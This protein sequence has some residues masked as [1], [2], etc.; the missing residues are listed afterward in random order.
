MFIENGNFHNEDQLILSGWQQET[1]KQTE[2]ATLSIW[3]RQ[4]NETVFAAPHPAVV[5]FYGGG[6]IHRN[7]G[8]FKRQGE[9]LAELGLTA[10]LADYRS[11][12]AYGGT[13]FDCVADAKSCLRHIRA[14]AERFHIRPDMIAAGGGSAGGHLAAAAA[15]LPGLNASEDPIVSAVPNALVL[16]NPVYDNSADG[17]GYDRVSERWQEI[18]PMEHIREGAPPQIVFLGTHDHLVPVATAERWQSRMSELGVRSDLHL[19]PERAHGFFNTGEDY[20]DTLDKT[21]AFLDS[22]GYIRRAG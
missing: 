22:L 4:P 5:F 8:Q 6:W 11:E 20:T 15:L 18:S 13:P 9:R 3:F 7:I 14:A 19:Y 16:F 12:N 21:I 1:Y 2:D 10:F 17:Y